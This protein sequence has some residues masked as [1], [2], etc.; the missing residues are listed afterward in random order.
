MRESFSEFQVESDAIGKMTEMRDQGVLAF[1]G[2]SFSC[3]SEAL[4]AAAWNLPLV[5]FV[6]IFNFLSGNF[7]IPNF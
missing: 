6:K 3:K 5:A 4:V 2:S 1:V 7:F